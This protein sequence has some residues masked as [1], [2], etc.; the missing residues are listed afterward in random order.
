MAITVTTTIQ[1]LNPAD[2]RRK[3]IQTVLGAC[4]AGIG[5]VMWSMNGTRTYP[6]LVVVFIGAQGLS[7]FLLSLY[8][9]IGHHR[10]KD[11]LKEY[12]HIPPDLRG[13]AML[14]DSMSKRGSFGNQDPLMFMKLWGWF[15][16]FLSVIFFLG[17][18]LAMETYSREMTSYFV[19]GAVALFWGAIIAADWKRTKR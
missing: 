9:W 4:V 8:D 3:I 10:V 6:N 19:V 11:R 14:G 18:D 12:Q 1:L 15:L 13:L 7:L 5:S 2:Y 16:P 17:D